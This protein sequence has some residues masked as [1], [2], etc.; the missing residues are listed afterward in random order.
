V[1]D[2]WDREILVIMPVEEDVQ[3]VDLIL[4]E[5]FEERVPDTIEE[6]L[7]VNHGVSLGLIAGNKPNAVKSQSSKNTITTML[8]MPLM[9]ASMG[10]YV[11][12]R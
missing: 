10:M 4:G 11:F 7:S 6:V 3:P 8:R 1:V 5:G 12:I 9:L 2:V